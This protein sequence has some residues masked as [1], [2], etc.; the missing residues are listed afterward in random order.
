MSHRDFHNLPRVERMLREKL[1]ISLAEVKSI[2]TST[3][4][5][6]FKRKLAALDYGKDYNPQGK[7]PSS[8]TWS[9]GNSFQDE[10]QFRQMVVWL[11]DMKIRF[12][13]IDGRQA[14]RDVQ[15]SAWE[16][17]LLK[18]IYSNIDRSFQW[19]FIVF[20]RF[21]VSLWEWNYSRS[22]CTQWLA[23]RCGYS[24]WIWW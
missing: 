17:A 21:E 20:T 14:L 10:K 19:I 15:N 11:E 24:I 16:Q 3:R 22:Y 6:M 2:I 5:I 7:I 18:V 12:Y 4:I 9:L 8:I 23:I 13:P 1:S